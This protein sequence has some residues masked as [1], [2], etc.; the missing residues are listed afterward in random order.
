MGWEWIVGEQSVEYSPPEFVARLQIAMRDAAYGLRRT[1]EQF[2]RRTKS[3]VVFV[4]PLFE[5]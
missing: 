3:E 2:T 1:A 5:G 4:Q